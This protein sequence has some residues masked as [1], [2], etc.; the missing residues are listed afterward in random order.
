MGHSNSATPSGGVRE[1]TGT[2]ARGLRA[3]EAEAKDCAGRYLVGDQITLAD[4]CLVPQLFGARAP[5]R[6][7]VRA[8]LPTR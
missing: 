1:G 5:G 3:L 2:F 7:P 8:H 6:T 4:L